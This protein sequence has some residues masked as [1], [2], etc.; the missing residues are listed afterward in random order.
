MARFGRGAPRGIR[1]WVVAALP[2]FVVGSRAEIQTRREGDNMKFTSD[3]NQE[4]CMRRNSKASVFALSFALWAGSTAAADPALTKIDYPG[5][6]SS[7]VWA[8]NTG[9][10]LVGYYTDPDRSNHGFLYSAGQYNA[11]NYPGADGT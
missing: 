11:I 5:A 4:N 9:G 7:Q 6:P 1:R 2:G 3:P 8:M 10:D